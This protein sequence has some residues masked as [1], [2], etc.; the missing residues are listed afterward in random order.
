MA[1]GCGFFRSA[2][3]NA[4]IYMGCLLERR[5]RLKQVYVRRIAYREQFFF[6]ARRF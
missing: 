1:Q 3:P 4:G 6:F 2:S 5:A